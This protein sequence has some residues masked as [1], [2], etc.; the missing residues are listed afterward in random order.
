[1]VKKIGLVIAMVVFLAGS[2]IPSFAVSAPRAEAE[3]R[4]SGR[5][6][7]L[8][9]SSRSFSVPFYAGY[10]GAVAL[11]GDGDTDLDLYVYDPNGNLVA[12]DDDESDYCIV[13][14][15]PRWTGL[16]TVK[17]VNRGRVYND[18]GIAVS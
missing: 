13:G 2:S 4:Y 7:V 3:V 8:A 18:F 5:Y 6:R 12:S 14:F 15:T 1:M 9:Y 11:R 10:A 16:Y 17:I